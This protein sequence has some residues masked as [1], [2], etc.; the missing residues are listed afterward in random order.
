VFRKRPPASGVERRCRIVHA[1]QQ[2]AGEGESQVVNQ[3]VTGSSGLTVA[4]QGLD[5]AVL[6]IGGYILTETV[7][8]RVDAGCFA[9]GRVQQPVQ[10]VVGE[11]VA[12]DGAFIPCLLGHAAD[13]AVVP[14]SAVT[15]IVVQVL[16]ELTS[17]DARQPVADIVRIRQLVCTTSVQ[18]L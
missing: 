13:A 8:V 16:C 4:L 11:L 14:G 9:V 6:V 1:V 3:S 12:A 15:G 2:I 5:V 17:A 7:G 18:G 10:P